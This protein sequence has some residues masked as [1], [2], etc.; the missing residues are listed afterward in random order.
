MD[1][2]LPLALTVIRL[3]VNVLA[4]QQTIAAVQR[5]IEGV[6]AGGGHVA[7]AVHGVL[8]ATG[9]GILPI[10]RTDTAL[11][12]VTAHTGT[13]QHLRPLGQGRRIVL[14]DVALHTEACRLHDGHEG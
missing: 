7:A 6:L 13:D 2:L 1:T 9:G 10:N 5:H 8:I 14:I 3:D 11:P 4:H 12:D